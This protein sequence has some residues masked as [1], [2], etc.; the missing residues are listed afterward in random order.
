[1]AC[2]L[3]VM[4]K[5]RT[6]LR[7]QLQP[8]DRTALWSSHVAKEGLLVVFWWAVPSFAIVLLV[9]HYRDHLPSAY[10]ESAISEGIGPH[11]WNVIGTLGLVL[12]GFALLL[13]RSR[14]IARSA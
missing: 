13:P 8:F 12:V 10:L 2:E 9:A 11:L 14:F 1:M 3:M 4:H 7:T 6:Y 5:L